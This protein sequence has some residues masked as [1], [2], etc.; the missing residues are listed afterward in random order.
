MTN[1]TNKATTTKL[2]KWQRLITAGL[3]DIAS[4]QSLDN[5]SSYLVLDTYLR[6]HLSHPPTVSEYNSAFRAAAL[7]EKKGLIRRVHGPARHEKR[8]KFD[9]SLLIYDVNVP[10]DNAFRHIQTE[11]H[12]YS[13]EQYHDEID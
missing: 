13:Q 12:N 10:R 11:S 3:A 8:T 4:N 9:R 1:Q 7:L 6:Q 5:S 2:G